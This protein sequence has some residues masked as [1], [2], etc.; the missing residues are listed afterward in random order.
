MVR[1]AADTAGFGVFTDYHDRDPYRIGAGDGCKPGELE[2]VIYNT[3]RCG[4]HLRLQPSVVVSRPG[5]TTASRAFEPCGCAEKEAFCL[6]LSRCPLSE[7]VAARHDG[8]RTT[9]CPQNGEVLVKDAVERLAKRTACVS[10]AGS[11]N[12]EA[13]PP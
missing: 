11:R 2:C 4:R 9:H 8:Q 13:T 7:V 12:R 1:P 5:Q 3:R 10:R 6:D